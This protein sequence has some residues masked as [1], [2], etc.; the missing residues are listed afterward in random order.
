MYLALVYCSHELA[1]VLQ[2]EEL[3]RVQPS[4]ANQQQQPPSTR[5]EY[6]QVA[7]QERRL[8][9]EESS[10]VSDLPIVVVFIVAFDVKS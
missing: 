3:D 2:Q 4:S 5:E 7:R 10:S 8:Q 9:R 1:M 6:E